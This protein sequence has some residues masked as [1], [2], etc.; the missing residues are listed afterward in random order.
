[1][2]SPF[3]S[4]HPHPLQCCIAHKIHESHEFVQV[5]E[6]YRPRKRWSPH[7]CHKTLQETNICNVLSSGAIF[8]AVLNYRTACWNLIISALSQNCF[9]LYFFLTSLIPSTFIFV[10]FLL[11]PFSFRV[12]VVPSIVFLCKEDLSHLTEHCVQRVTLYLTNIG[13]QVK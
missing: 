1:M 8:V 10:I 3:T 4:H 11:K 13:L 9:L 7:S 5:W 6:T 2:F 12:Q